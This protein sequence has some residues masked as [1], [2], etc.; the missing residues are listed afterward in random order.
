[1]KVNT[2]NDM[3]KLKVSLLG[4]FAITYA[5]LIVAAV[6][7]FVAAY[8][9]HE[10]IKRL[11]HSIHEVYVP[12]ILFL[13]EFEVMLFESQDAEI[14]H[15]VIM[16][17]YSSLKKDYKKHLA[18]YWGK[19]EKSEQMMAAFEAMLIARDGLVKLLHADEFE[20]SQLTQISAGEIREKL[21]KQVSQ[22]KKMLEGVIQAQERK[23]SSV[24][25]DKESADYVLVVLVTLLLLIFFIGGLIFLYQLNSKVFKPHSQ[26][27]NTIVE[28][29]EGKSI[30]ANFEIG[31]DEIM[32]RA[33]NNLVSDLKTMTSFAVAI[34]NGDYNNDLKL[35]RVGDDMSR[36]LLEMRE[37][38][39]Q[40]S[41]E[42][43]QRNWAVSGLARFADIIRSQTDLKSLGDSIISEMVKYTSSNQGALFI[44]EDEDTDDP[45]LKMTACYAW[46]KKRF[47]NKEIRPGQGLTGECWQEGEPIFMTHIPQDYVHITSGLGEATPGCV[48]ISPLKVNNKIYGIL[49]LATFKPY[50]EHEREFVIKVSE[51]IASA[52]FNAK[53]NE[54]TQ[55]LLEQSQQQ[56]EDM[57]AS[58]EELRQNMEE[59]QATQEA[60]ERKN[61]ELERANVQAEAQKQSMSRILEKLRQ[62]ERENQEQSKELKAQEEELRQSI[63]E[64]RA[65]QEATEKRNLELERANAQAE[66]QKQTMRK[67]LEKLT[68]KDIEN[69]EKAEQ[70]KAQEEMMRQSM[71]ELL[72]AQEEA[73]KKN[74]ELERANAQAEAQK[75]SMAKVIKKLQ[76]A[77]KLN[78]EQTEELRVR[79][80]KLRRNMEE[81]IAMQEEMERA[82]K[83]EKQGSV[84][85][86]K[87]ITEELTAKLRTAE[88]E[89]KRLRSLNR[90]QN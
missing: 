29:S 20:T 3:T 70:I 74:L 51:N 32:C 24:V 84:E 2:E 14:A 15:H 59:L 25:V 65:T 69:K 31:Q 18:I 58:E 40:T 86:Q 90:S 50:Q 13:R 30:S 26:L 19:D 17:K 83:L 78:K 52:I 77:E 68:Q 28:I 44:V 55:Q 35:T 7:I 11:D 41:V 61:I 63:E 73:K 75:Q 21:K 49:E 88:E 43:K 46:D 79:E 85:V 34:G 81:L 8:T 64:L 54:Q 80:E 48:F 23:V 42:E 87:K 10:H 62:K 60:A 82:R 38:L 4:K 66:A 76:D 22:I 5:L 89:V 33:L 12:T 37:N 72:K 56:A 67:M 57:K 6:A 9:K 53:V 45:F 71:E 47:I 36:A 27:R 39:M 16:A 1:M